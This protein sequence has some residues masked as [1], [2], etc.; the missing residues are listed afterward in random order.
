MLT[1]GRHSAIATGLFS[2]AIYPASFVLLLVF[3]GSFTT[4][5]IFICTYGVA[6]GLNT[7]ARGSAPLQ[8]FGSAGYGERLGKIVAPVKVMSAAGAVTYAYILERRSLGVTLALTIALMM[9]SLASL[10]LAAKRLKA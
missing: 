9:L 6:N 5:L 4:A 10:A 3:G 2:S 7:I 1:S 8:L